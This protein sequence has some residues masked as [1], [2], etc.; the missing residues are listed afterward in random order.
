[1]SVA[2]C[3]AHIDARWNHVWCWC[4]VWYL[5]FSRGLWY[6]LTSL[7]NA[8]IKPLVQ[9]RAVNTVDQ[10]VPKMIARMSRTV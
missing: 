7:G 9:S 8:L 10:I 1:M 4:L 6:L 5:L 3:A 2:S